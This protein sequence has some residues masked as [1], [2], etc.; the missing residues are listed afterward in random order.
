VV[1]LSG[2]HGERL[3]IA[4][5]LIR[6]G[7]TATLVLDG[8]PDSPEALELC[9]ERQVFEVVCLRPNPDSTRAEARAAGELA[10]DRG[11]RSLIVVT[12]AY[13]VPRSALLFLR[14]FDGSVA[15]IGA[16]PPYGW[17]RSFDAITHEWL[18]LGHALTLDRGC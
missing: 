14:C 17:R 11:W 4:L 16:D 7:V 10:A 6:E 9:R 5:R 8:T 12:T 2:D 18:A 13:H 1:V 3:R 15:V